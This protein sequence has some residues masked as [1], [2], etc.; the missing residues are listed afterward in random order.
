MSHSV[1]ELRMFSK[2]FRLICLD[3]PER[4]WVRNRVRTRTIANGLEL[5]DHGKIRT[6]VFTKR[7]KLLPSRTGCGGT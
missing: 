2:G 7:Q 1:P 3:P 6:I 4:V 5:E